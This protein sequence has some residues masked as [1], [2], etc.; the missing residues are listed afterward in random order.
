MASIFTKSDKYK[1]EYSCRVVRIGPVTPIENSTYLGWTLIGSS[2]VVVR[3]DSIHEGDVMFY[4]ARETQISSVFAHRNNCYMFDKYK[5]NANADEVAA[6]LAEAETLD[7][8]AKEAKIAE[9]KRM[10][11]YLNEKSRIRTATLCGVPSAGYLF[12]LNELITWKPE[13]KE[14]FDEHTIDEFENEFFD[15]VADELFCKAYVPKTNQKKRRPRRLTK[16][17]RRV[18]KYFGWLPEKYQRMIIRKFQKP[19][20]KLSKKEKRVANLSYFVPGE[21]EWHYDT[22]QLGDNIWKFGPD[23]VVTIST[24]CHGTS[25]S[26]GNVLREFPEP[27]VPSSILLKNKIIDALHF[28]KKWKGKTTF[29]GHDY[30][31][32]TRNVLQNKDMNP[33]AK[34]YDNK[35]VYVEYYKIFKE[36]DCLD[37]DMMVY[38]EIVGY[39]NGEK[40]CI[41]VTGGCSFDY[42]CKEGENAFMP[43]R[44]TTKLPDGKKYEWNVVD[45]K[46]WTEEL[47]KK[48]PQLVGKIVPIDLLYHGTLRDLYPELDTTQHWHQ[49]LIMK[50]KVDER[51]CMEREEP[52]CKNKVPREGICIRKD[53]DPEPECF[54]LKTEKFYAL[55]SKSVDKG[56]IADI[57]MMDEY[58]S[59]DDESEDGE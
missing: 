48:H 45:V 23:D 26:Y 53:N 46:A 25:G 7:G 9:A 31:Y 54:K 41:Q 4:S 40:K 49:N 42:G 51:F 19:R 12:G 5:M 30:L 57:E 13:L 15:T 27:V 37:R 56:K 21:F 8:E 3:K 18:K 52:L 10:C 34:V 35:D 17:E 29:T 43:Y 58:G 44:I 6:V 20:R 32:S 47:L 59:D 2:T 1:E 39:F 16:V 24:K 36:L 28:P 14:Y 33:K 11:G 50:L 22:N 38:G 55:E